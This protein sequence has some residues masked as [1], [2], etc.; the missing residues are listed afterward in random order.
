MQ[1][2]TAF[3]KLREFS[4][5][6][7]FGKKVPFYLH[8]LKQFDNCFFGLKSGSKWLQGRTT[9]TIGA[10]KSISNVHLSQKET[11]IF[12]GVW[13]TFPISYFELCQVAL[14]ISPQADNLRFF[15]S[16]LWWKEWHP[17]ICSAFIFLIES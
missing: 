9:A 7:Y 11:N 14:V 4:Q 16:V 3:T 8:I 2:K 10:V 5:I 12:I 6:F 13:G 1:F 15:K 17:F